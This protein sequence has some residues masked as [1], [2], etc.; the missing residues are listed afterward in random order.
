[1]SVSLP[2]VGHATQCLPIRE[3][4]YDIT[5]PALELPAQREFGGVGSLYKTTVHQE[6]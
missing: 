3:G 6:L 5:Y 4:L 1:M 2:D